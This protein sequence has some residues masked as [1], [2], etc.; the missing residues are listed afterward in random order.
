MPIR[1]HK[2]QIETCLHVKSICESIGPFSKSEIEDDPKQ[3]PHIHGQNL[4]QSGVLGHRRVRM[5]CTSGLTVI[6]IGCWRRCRQRGRRTVNCLS[7]VSLNLRMLLQMRHFISWGWRQL[8][9]HS[10][11]PHRSSLQLR[12]SLISYNP[13]ATQTLIRSDKLWGGVWPKSN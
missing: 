7:V 1:G 12:I 8:H 10:S 6:G 9:L 4:G 5:E 3:N 2:P 11:I 13:G